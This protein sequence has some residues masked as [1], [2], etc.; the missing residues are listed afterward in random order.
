MKKLIIFSLFLTACS[1]NPFNKNKTEKPNLMEKK[2]KKQL[3]VKNEFLF[4]GKK[5]I[6]E[7][8]FTGMG[9]KVEIIPIREESSIYQAR[10]GSEVK[11]EQI[12]SDLKGQLDVIEPNLIYEPSFENQRRKWPKDK[13]FFNQW[14]L[15]NV[16]QSAPFGLP[17]QRGADL[18]AMKLISE[19]IRGSKEVVVAIIDTGIDYTHPELKDNM[20]LN[21]AEVDGIDGIDD[22]KNG[23]VDDKYGFDFFSQDKTKLWYGK[24]GDADPKDENGHGTHCAGVVGAKGDN[25]IGI[26]GLNQN[27]RLMAIKIF[28]SDGGATSADTQ[29]GIYYAIDRKVDLMSNSW[30]GSKSSELTQKAI[31]EAD[32]K[33]IVFVAAA[34]NENTNNDVEARFPSAYRYRTDPTKRIS[35][36]ISVGAS[37]NQDNAAS[38]SNYGY[39]TVDVFAPGVLIMSTYPTDLTKEGKPPYMVMSGTSMAT[40][41]VSGVVALMMAANPELKGQP[42]KIRQILVDSSD[43]SPNLVGKSVSNGRVNAYKA[44]KFLK[45]K[46][47]TLSEWET[48]PNVINGRGPYQELVDIRHKIEHKGAKAISAHFDF[49]QITEPYDSVYIYDKNM[50]YITSME[51]TESVDVWSPIVPGDTMYVRFVNAKLRAIKMSV[52]MEAATESDC[53]DIGGVLKLQKGKYGCR[54]DTQDSSG[55]GSEVYNSFHSEGF[56]IDKIKYA[57]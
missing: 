52:N 51:K 13:Y 8:Y 17:G 37:D 36:I 6:V 14:Y 53:D 7:A 56:T 40:P 26:V 49:I 2:V 24:A 20:W 22:D 39:E 28:G 10:H 44:V 19:G 50:K 57:M 21:K 12:V 27:V 23:F 9:L 11:Y 34:G 38:F 18:D 48:K 4:E 31:E 41:L 5:S 35:N 1:Y 25:D 29:R 33:G 47:L 42:E 45:D 54:V 15:N 3:S 43:S 55:E 16:G 32:K 30:G 46:N